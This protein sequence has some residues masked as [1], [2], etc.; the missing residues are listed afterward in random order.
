M[1]LDDQSEIIEMV[2]RQYAGLGPAA[3]RTTRCEV[4]IVGNI[5]VALAGCETVRDRRTG[6][7]DV[8]GYLLTRTPEGWRIAAQ[9]WGVVTDI[10]EAFAAAGL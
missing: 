2:R 8:S 9:N 10:G 4:W 1:T 6:K 5:A 7:H 3:G